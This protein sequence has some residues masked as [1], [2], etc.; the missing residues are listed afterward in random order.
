VISVSATNLATIGSYNLNLERLSPPPS[1]DV[2]P[3]MCGVNLGQ[4]DAAG[5]TDLFSHMG[6]AGEIISL[7]LASTGGFASNGG[8]R[9]VSLSVF[10]PSGLL[11]GSL[12]SNDQANFTLPEAG[13][14]IIRVNA[15]NLATTGTYEVRFACF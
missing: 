5:E 12:R 7:T 2:V 1:P 6:Q 4:I 3:L 11:A 14:Y 13:A 8:G 15:T 9:S 10:A